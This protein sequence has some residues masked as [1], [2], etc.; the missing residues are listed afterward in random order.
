[1]LI[2]FLQ[3]NRGLAFNRMFAMMAYPQDIMP[4]YAQGH[5]VARYL[6]EQGGKR[7]YVDFVGEGLKTRDWPGAVRKHY[8]VRDLGVLQVTWL[9]WVKQGSPPLSRPEAPATQL[10]S[11]QSR[12]QAQQPLYRGQSADPVTPVR[13]VSNE[14]PVRG[15]GSKVAWPP[16]AASP[17]RSAASPRQPEAAAAIEQN[18]LSLPLDIPVHAPRKVL[19]EWDATPSGDSPALPAPSAADSAAQGRVSRRAPLLDAGM[20][21]TRWR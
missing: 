14:T 17:L 10:A 15:D 20:T 21:S 6:I 9:D 3:T 19:L 5:S 13:A 11:N 18:A 2:Q 8:G 1:M 12:P 16:T 4:L 7:K